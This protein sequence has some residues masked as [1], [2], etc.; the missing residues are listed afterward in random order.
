MRKVK[1]GTVPVVFLPKFQ[2]SAHPYPTNF[3]KL[4]SVNPTSKLSGDQNTEYLSEA[5]LLGMSF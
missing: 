5:K 1:T 4:N 2:M 3:W